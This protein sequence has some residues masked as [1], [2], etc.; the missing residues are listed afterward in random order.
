ML[1]STGPDHS[2]Y[3]ECAVHHAG[4]ELGRG[5]GR[6]KKLAESAAAAAALQ[7]VRE[8]GQNPS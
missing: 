2:R 1:S 4:E 3:F 7:R 6:S 8:R 5:T